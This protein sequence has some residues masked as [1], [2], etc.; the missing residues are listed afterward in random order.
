MFGA[1]EFKMGQKIV[2]T[3]IWSCLGLILDMAYY[4][5]SYSTDVKEALECKSMGNSN[6][7]ALGS[8]KVIGNITIRYDFLLTFRTN[9]V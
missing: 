6:L 5:F 4:S 3:P 7:S 8:F 9:Y 1:P 2:I